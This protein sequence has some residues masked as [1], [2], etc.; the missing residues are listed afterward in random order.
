LG[1][2]GS[3]EE[4]RSFE[5]FRSRTAHQLSGFFDSSFWDRLLLQATHCEPALRHAV[6]A[7][8]SLHE[9]FELR[10]ETIQHPLWKGSEGGFALQHYNDAIGA[11]IK[12][13]HESQQAVDVC[14]M[15][16]MLFACF[17][18]RMIKLKSL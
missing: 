10:D 15:S 12:P 14:L 2:Q 16:C 17:E 6:L 4:C 11:L 8:S 1:F 9:R 5:Y 7:L 18:V 3:E 13:S